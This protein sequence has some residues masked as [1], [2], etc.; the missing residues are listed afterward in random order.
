MN[1]ESVL[2]VL[3]AHRE[4][5]AAAGVEH[6]GVFGSVARG[7][8]GPDSDID[9]PVEFTAGRVPDVFAHVGLKD[10]ISTRFPGRVDVVNARGLRPSV[11][12]RVMRD[13]VH[14]F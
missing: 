7:E 14:A 5:L 2:A 3:R 4:E 1:R 13:L 12:A 10:R 8:A 6:A 9:V 11:R